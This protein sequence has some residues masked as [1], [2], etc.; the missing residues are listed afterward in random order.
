M[1]VT[2]VAN[3][4]NGAAAANPA[5]APQAGAAP[6]GEPA[7]TATDPLAAPSDSASTPATNIFAGFMDPFDYDPRGRRDPFSLPID[8]K[9]MAQGQLHVPLLPLQR[10]ELN[11]FRLMGIMWDVRSPKAML[12]DPSGQIHIIGPNAKIGPRN[13]YVAVIRE[14]EIVVVETMEQEGRLIST[15]QVVKIAK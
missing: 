5:A 9:P 6:A 2:S 8:D 3:A 10:Y 1:L 12:K 14:G 13:G 4:Q 11:Q 7:K 15:A